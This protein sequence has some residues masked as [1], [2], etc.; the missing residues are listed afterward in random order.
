VAA[1]N[2]GVT[3]STL[4]RWM[5]DPRQE[6][7]AFRRECELA[8]KMAKLAML[9]NVVTWVKNEKDARLTMEL[10]ARL[11]PE[12]FGNRRTDAA[13]F[14]IEIDKEGNVLSPHEGGAVTLLD[15]FGGGEALEGATAERQALIEE[16]GADTQTT[17]VVHGT[18]PEA[19]REAEKRADAAADRAI[20][21]DAPSTAQ[22]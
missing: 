1:A 7:A 13:G 6:Y 4:K 16:W 17:L 8:T 20:A 19:D 3:G 12:T 15:F 18:V 5:K 9:N 11:W 2:G 10:M 22:G 14:P 21:E